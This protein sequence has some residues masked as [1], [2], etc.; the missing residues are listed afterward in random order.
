[1]EMENST[2]LQGDD[3]DDQFKLTGNGCLSQTPTQI[4][5]LTSQATG[6]TGEIARV[7]TLKKTN[8]AHLPLGTR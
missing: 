3:L 6:L 1:M 4:F 8:T 5:Y 2:C 7:L